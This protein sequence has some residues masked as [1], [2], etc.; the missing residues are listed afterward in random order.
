MSAADFVVQEQGGGRT[1]ALTGDWTAVTLGGVAGRLA[2]ALH[3]QPA[4]RVDVTGLGRIDTSGAYALFT[5]QEGAEAPPGLEG[6]PEAVRLY[7]LV[8]RS[9]ESEARPP[10]RRRGDPL[11]RQL[12]K[13]G[14]GVMRLFGEG[15]GLLAFNGRLILTLAKL[16]TQPWRLRG[17]P[18]VNQMDRAGLDAL[19]IIC[20]LSFFVGAVVALIGA[21]LLA[22]FGATV[23]VVEL[24]G[25]AVLREFGVLIT[26]I[27]L[28]G[29]SASSFAAEIGS[30]RMNQEIDAMQV[31]GVDPFEALVA[32]RLLGLVL[33]IPLLTFGAVI[34]GLLGGMA[35]AWGAL[36]LSPIFFVDRILTNVGLT[37]FLVGLVKA[38]VFAIVIAAIGCRQ[39]M[40]VEGDVE[41]LGERVTIAVVQAIFAIIVIDAVFALVFLE[42]DV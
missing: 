38:P 25:V 6:R 24:I 8:R 34:A 11:T 40:L 14:H 33:M 9:V 16:L 39:G 19:P 41:S 37:Q 18:L 20:T 5:A 4:D 27:L 21:N 35:V 26:A 23:F 31:I 2:S 32:P 15:Y 17:A 28:A 10:A 22:Q 30:M 36:E 12:A 13:I 7:D 3:R 42:L 29:R 1:L